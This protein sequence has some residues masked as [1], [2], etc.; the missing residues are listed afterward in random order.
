MEQ[1][2]LTGS[3]PEEMKL[4]KE[5][6]ESL[7][8]RPQNR[9]LPGKISSTVT[10]R[11]SSRE[12][13]PGRRFMTT[14]EDAVLIDTNVPADAAG[15]SSPFYSESR[16]FRDRGPN[17]AYLP[18]VTPQILFEF[19]AVVTDPRRVGPPLSPEDAT[20]E[21][22]QYFSDP[23]SARFVPAG[24]SANSY[25]GSFAITTSRARMSSMPRSPRR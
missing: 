25:S 17:G 14:S 1:V 2:D 5:F 4:I 22:A 23:K 7:R 21:P 6:L 24:G 8:A 19:Y 16:A 20:A 13:S 3:R 11:W 15:R 9:R 12:R 10:G 18:C